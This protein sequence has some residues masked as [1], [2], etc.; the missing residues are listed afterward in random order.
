MWDRLKQIERRY[1]DLDQEMAKPELATDLKKLQALAREKA[2]IEEVVTRYHH[3]QKTSKE[4]EKT[5]SMLT[6]ELD[7]EMS[8]MVK[9]EIEKLE[10][11][12]GREGH[13][14]GNP[15]GD[16]WQ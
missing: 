13:H 7:E 1:R 4:L 9:Q 2:G 10:K 11:K 5:K 8:T 16:G 3:Y 14:N 15:G 6:T 12:L